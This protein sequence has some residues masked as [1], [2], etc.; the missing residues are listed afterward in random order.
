M[1]TLRVTVQT[2]RWGVA[3]RLTTEVTALEPNRLLVEEQRQGPFRRWIV[4]R[5]LEPLGGGRTRLA[6]AVEFDPPGGMLGLRATAVRIEA[7]LGELFAHRNAQ[8]AV[9]LGG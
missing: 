5:T 9:L 1:L 4:T 7:E 2:R 6:E 8:L 3:I